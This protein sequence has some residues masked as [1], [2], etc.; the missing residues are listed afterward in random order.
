MLYQ[1]PMATGFVALTSLEDRNNSVVRIITNVGRID[2]ELFE[3]LV[4]SVTANFRNYITSGKHDEEFFHSMAAGVLQSGKYKF[5]DGTGLATVTPNSPISNG[6]SRSN[7]QRT[8][9]MVPINTIQADSQ[10]IINLQDNLGLNTLSGGYTVFGKVIQGWDIVTTIA[11]F[12]VRDLNV[13]LTGS[14]TGPFSAVPTTPAYNPGNGPTENTLVKIVD[15]ETIK[16]PGVAG[17]YSNTFVFPEGS[18]GAATTERLDIMN[19]DLDTNANNLNFFQIIIRYESGERD[20]VLY[21]GSLLPG[22]RFSFKVNDVNIPGFNLVRSGVGYAFDVRSTRKMA[23][24]LD[25]RDTGVTLAESFQMT[26]QIPVP[27]FTRYNFPYAKKSATENAFLLLQE[28][29]GKN[30]TINVLVYPASG[31]SVYLPVTLEAFRRGGINFNNFA[32]IPDGDFSILVTCLTPINAALSQF[33]TSAGVTEGS[34]QGGV[35]GLGRVEGALAGAYIATGGEAKINVNYTSAA[36]VVI[37]DFTITLTNGTVLTPSPVTLTLSNRR[38]SIDLTTIP[39]LPRDQYFAIQYSERQHVNPVSVSYY[40]KV[41]GDEMSTPFQINGT[42]TV[43][44]ADGFTD[45][46]LVGS[47][48]MSETISIFNPYANAGVTFVYDILFQFSDGTQLFAAAPGIFSLGALQRRDH[49]A[50]NIP[51]VL[52]KINSDPAFRFYSV[53]VITAA[54][55]TPVPIGGVVAQLTRLHNTWGQSLTTIPSLDPSHAVVYLDN[56]EF[57]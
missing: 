11:G 41:A 21:T 34:T 12:T 4:P 13:Q 15:V 2:I 48:G 31:G 40:S 53:Q 16:A 46:N 1:V 39:G 38:G 51:A 29:D 3:A 6:F 20:Q 17:Y 50:A 49:R 24:S 35:Q 5:N 36:A 55:G 43:M 10:F 27:Q 30:I 37:V 44:F 54:F 28:L 26:P 33:K 45:P 56:V 14:G 32:Q 52:A 7:L 42:P 47:N 19:E 9:S 22:R 25:H 8:V 23:V 18:R 57:N